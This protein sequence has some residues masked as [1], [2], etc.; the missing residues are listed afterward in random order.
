MKVVDSGYIGTSNDIAFIM[1]TNYHIKVVICLHNMNN[2]NIL[3]RNHNYTVSISLL[4][5]SCVY[6]GYTIGVKKKTFAIFHL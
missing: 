2:L 3:W 6:R 1:Y 4:F 5:Y